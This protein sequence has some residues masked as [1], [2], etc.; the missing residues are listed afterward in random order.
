MK[1]PLQVL[2]KW[3]ETISGKT[4]SYG[5]FIGRRARRGFQK[6]MPDKFLFKPPV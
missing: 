6:T 2:L 4:Y 1:T 5:E 3:Q